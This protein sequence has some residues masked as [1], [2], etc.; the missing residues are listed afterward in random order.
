MAAVMIKVRKNNVWSQCMNEQKVH[1]QVV[2]VEDV[3][4]VV[5]ERS[6]RREYHRTHITKMFICSVVH[7]SE[8]VVDD[9]LNVQEV[10]MF[11]ST[12]D[13]ISVKTV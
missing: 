2:L 12:G 1:P 9:V 10:F 13:H 5:C 11:M 7:I 4:C 3:V 8:R 6:F